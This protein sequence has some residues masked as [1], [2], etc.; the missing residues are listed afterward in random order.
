ME[1]PY[2]KPQPGYCRVN[3]KLPSTGSEERAQAH[4]ACTE[5][6]LLAWLVT[7]GCTSNSLVSLTENCN[8]KA[9]EDE[10][11]DPISQTVLFTPLSCNSK[12]WKTA[13]TAW[14]SDPT[15]QLPSFLLDLFGFCF[16]F[17]FVLFF[18]WFGSFETGSHIALAGLKLIIKS[19][20]TLN[21]WSSCF[22]L[23]SVGI[24]ACKTMPKFPW[25]ISTINKS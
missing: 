9:L 23:L 17:C 10:H 12:L 11:N 25:F 20:M 14:Y 21:F 15:L 8:G 19:R 3:A 4:K 7:S 13:E 24:I 5:L 18:F 6:L 2:G 16:L 1:K 22:Y